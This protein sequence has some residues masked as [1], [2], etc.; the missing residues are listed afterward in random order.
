MNLD[1]RSQVLLDT[2]HRTQHAH[3][4]RFVCAE[5]K[6]AEL[7]AVQPR[8]LCSHPAA[9]FH[10]RTLFAGQPGCADF[11]PQRGVDV[12][13]GLYAAVVSEAATAAVGGTP[14]YAA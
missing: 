11:V 7:F 12:R 9:A 13:L 14:S 6:Y 2:S 8:A 1:F 4:G 3:Y 5:C 10:G